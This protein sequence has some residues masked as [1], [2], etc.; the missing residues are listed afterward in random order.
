[1]SALGLLF[2]TGLL[3]SLHCLGMC[4]PFVMM[5]SA[6]QPGWGGVAGYHAGRL[7]TYAGLGLLAGGAG[8]WVQA[9]HQWGP[10]LVGGMAGALTMAMGLSLLGLPLPVPPGW[11][12]Q[13]S[14]W[15]ARLGPMALGACAGALPCGLLYG[16][17]AQ[18]TLW[19]PL[20][21]MALMVG[22]W[23]GTVPALVVVGGGLERLP[24]G[25]R[26]RFRNAAAWSLVA[27]GAGVTLV[28]VAPYIPGLA[29]LPFCS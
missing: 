6:R 21:G 1:M 10:P 27:M 17:I 3:G 7:F 18:A 9:W 25:W 15:L 20:P 5:A 12:A 22:F 26:G 28:R 11:S 13:L 29:S 14:R 8:A 19:G 16:A 23:A 24:L 2:V 4:G